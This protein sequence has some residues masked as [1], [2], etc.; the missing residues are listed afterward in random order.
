MIDQNSKTP[1]PDGS[2]HAAPFNAQ[3]TSIALGIY[4]PSEPSKRGYTQ[5]YKI[6]KATKNGARFV[7]V[8]AELNSLKYI[9]LADHD[10]PY[11]YVSKRLLQSL[12]D[13]GGNIPVT[14]TIRLE[15]VEWTE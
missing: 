5:T 11:F 3:E 12:A 13:E 1:Q 4:G 6:Q 10:F 8:D 7:A 15:P 14:L 2:G 9:N